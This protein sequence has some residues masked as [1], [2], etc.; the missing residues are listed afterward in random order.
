[1]GDGAR[2]RARDCLDNVRIGKTMQ[3]YSNARHPGQKQKAPRLPLTTAERSAVRKARVRLGTVYRQHGEDLSN[4][5]GIPPERCRQRVAL[6]QVQTLDSVGPSIA[7]DL[8]ALGFRSIPDLAQAAPS[9]MDQ[10]LCHMVG[11]RIDPRVED[12]FRCAVARARG[13]KRPDYARLWWSWTPYRGTNCVD[14]QDVN[15]R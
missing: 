11:W 5:S 14:P 6:G 1:M 8:F 7:D 13:P 3:H 15:Q 2:A 9:G 10:K 4:L 12:V